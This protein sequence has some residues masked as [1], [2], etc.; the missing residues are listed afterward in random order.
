MRLVKIDDIKGNEVLAMSV[1]T[2]G[3]R[4]LLAEGTVLK[5]EYIPKLVSHGISE[6][7]IKDN[8]IS[9]KSVSILREEIS[10]KCREQIRSII[11]KHIYNDSLREMHVLAQT[12]DDIIS[13]IM[14]EEKVVEQIYDIRERSADLYEHSINT[15]SLA[16]LVALKMGLD[17][18]T[19]HDIGVGCLLH[20]IGLRYILVDYVGIDPDSM[21][22]KDSVE[23]KKHTVYGYSDF[24][25]ETWL[26]DLSKQIIL[27]HHERIDGSGYPLKITDIPVPVEIAAICDLFDESICGIGSSRMKVYEAVELLKSCK[28]IKFSGNI[29]DELL[30][31]T[32]VYPTKS[33]VV[34][35]NGD[36]AVV[37]SQNK[38][39]P[40]R[41]VLQLISDVNG[42]RYK[43]EEVV[44]L[45]EHNNLII[46][47]V[48]G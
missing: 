21:K 16:M 12:A 11:S 43:E 26:N 7:F 22:E 34:L 36:R 45:L 29:V 23:Y 32:A 10:K 6:V 44:D 25:A 24:K 47:K 14:E 3:Y 39:F 48:L 19:V 35:S 18:D 41:P 30:D 42:I 8:G 27:S 46:D 2:D 33:I 40:E 9:V 38:G 20:D 17:Y 13:E 5:K 15:C 28:D 1:M 37:I 4:E 31:F